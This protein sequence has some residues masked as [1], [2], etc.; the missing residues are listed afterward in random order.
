MSIGENLKNVRKSRGYTQAELTALAAVATAVAAAGGAAVKVGSDFEA[1]MSKVAA[2]S[3]ATGDELEALTEKAEEMGATTK[4]SATESAQALQYMA[5]AGW[6]TEDMLSGIDCIITLTAKTAVETA[7]VF[8]ITIKNIQ[9]SDVV[10]IDGIK[11]T[12]LCNGI[13]KFADVDLTSFRYYIPP[14]RSI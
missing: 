7:V 4:F 10:V 11:K 5:M 14:D 2:I 1:A 12:V 3:G 9:K 8:G 13:N 6:K